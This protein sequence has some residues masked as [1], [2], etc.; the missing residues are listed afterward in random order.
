M[1]P[2]ETALS[3]LQE[4]VDAYGQGTKGQPPDGSV[5]FYLLRAHSLGLSYLKRLEQLNLSQDAPAAHRLF[6]VQERSFKLI[7]VPPPVEIPS[8]ILPA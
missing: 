3:Q 7:A 6:A 8:D 2:L 4:E 1:T 5:E